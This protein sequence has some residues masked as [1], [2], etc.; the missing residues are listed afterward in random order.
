MGNYCGRTEAD[1]GIACLACGWAEWLSSLCRRIDS[2]RMVME[3][4]QCVQT[5]PHF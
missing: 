4:S 3:T 2:H 5:Q 1:T